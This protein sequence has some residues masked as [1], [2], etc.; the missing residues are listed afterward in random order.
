V[1]L[2]ALSCPRANWRPSRLLLFPTWVCV[3]CL[4]LTGAAMPHHM[5]NPAGGCAPIPGVTYDVQ[6]V[7]PPPIDPPAEIHP[8]LNLALRSYRLTVTNLG[9][10]DYQ[11]NPDALAPQLVGLFADRRTPAFTAA[12]QVRDW[13]WACSC[14]GPALAEPEVTLIGMTVTADE[15]LHVPD[16]GYTIGNGYEVLVLYASPERITLKY[17]REDSV[18]HGYTV[19]LENIC[20]DPNLLALYQASNDAGRAQLPALRPGQPFAR[21]RGDEVIVAIRDDGK[22]LDPRSRKDWWR[23]R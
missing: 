7:D 5:A 6:P 23:G 20:V 10:V 9:L 14:P 16:S 18:T 15:V 4:G 12:Y 21:A 8:D 2:T 1:T 3:V 13:D 22:F 17:T 11:G 19:H